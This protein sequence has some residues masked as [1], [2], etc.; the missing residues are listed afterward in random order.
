MSILRHAFNKKTIAILLAIITLASLLLA[1]P[2]MAKKGNT[3]DKENNI[4]MCW[5]GYGYQPCP[6][7]WGWWGPYWGWGGHYNRIGWCP[8]GWGYYQ[9]IWGK[10]GWEFKEYKFGH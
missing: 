4:S 3:P 6:P 7:N 2:V 10:S 1:S 8:G 9:W 5:W